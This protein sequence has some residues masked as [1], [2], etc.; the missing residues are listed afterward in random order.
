VI[1]LIRMRWAEHVANIG[2]GE[3]YTGLRWGNLRETDQLEDPGLNGRI[4]IEIFRKWHGG[5][6]L[7]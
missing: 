5:H 1:K 6:G 3:A 2:K 7:D 4:L